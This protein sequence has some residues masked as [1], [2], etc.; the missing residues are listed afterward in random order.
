M[1]DVGRDS[2]S[3][4]FGRY[5]PDLVLGVVGY[6]A[7]PEAERPQRWNRAAAGQPGIFREYLFRI[8]KKHEQ[9]QELVSAVYHCR[10]IECLAKV[11]SHR[12]AGMNEHSVAV[13]AHEE[14]NRFVHSPRLYAHG[15]SGKQDYLLAPLVQP[16]K[17]FAATEYLFFGRKLKARRHAAAKV[18]RAPHE[19]EGHRLGK[20][21]GCVPD[22]HCASQHLARA[23]EELEPPRVFDQPYL[24]ISALVGNGVLVFFDLP[25]IVARNRPCEH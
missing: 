16:G 25:R 4:E 5:V 8:S 13:A 17:R 10:F 21:L 18:N 12:S 3:A 9:V 24:A 15:I 22:I 7:H 6:P 20:G 14:W 2:I 11:E 19:R 23:I 1:N